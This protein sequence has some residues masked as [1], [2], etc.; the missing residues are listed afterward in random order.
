MSKYPE[1]E[2][3]KKR[4]KDALLVGDFYD[5]L[6]EQ[7][8]EIAKYDDKSERLFPIRLRPEEIIG[9]FLGVDPRKLEAEKRAMLE[10]IRQKG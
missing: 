2:K 3:L 6:N 9:L 10:E 5:F 1:H 8:W 4:E 7:E